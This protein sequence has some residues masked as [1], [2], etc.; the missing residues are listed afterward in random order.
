ME[1]KNEKNEKKQSAL[2]TSNHPLVKLFFKLWDIFMTREVITYL[3]SG[4]LTTLVNWVLYWLFVE[5]IGME[6]LS[7]NALDWVLTVA[8]AYVVNAFWVFDS[9]FTGWQAEGRKI[10]KFYAAR[11]LTFLVEEGGILIFVKQL[12]WNGLI[13]K[14]ALAVIVIILN[15]V[16]SKLFVFLKKSE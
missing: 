6:E 2:R 12:K 4:V 10:F 1:D 13:V 7:G 11:F 15:Y 3:I 9:K 5:K 16:F 14:A 8:F